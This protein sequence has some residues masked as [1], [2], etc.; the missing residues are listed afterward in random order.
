[1]TDILHDTYSRF[2]R[3]RLRQLSAAAIK[4]MQELE[5]GGLF[6]NVLGIDNLWDEACWAILDGFDD[7]AFEAA[8]LTLHQFASAEIQ[9]LLPEELSLHCYILSSETDEDNC[10]PPDK[11][12]MI[13]AVADKMHESANA[14]YFDDFEEIFPEEETDVDGAWALRFADRECL[15]TIKETVGAWRTRARSGHD[16]LALG[17]ILTGLESILDGNDPGMVV[18]VGLTNA[19]GVSD[20]ELEIDGQCLEIAL[21]DEGIELCRTLYFP[22]GQGRSRDH[23]TDVFAVL[24]PSGDF[25]RN[26]VDSWSSNC[27]D[28]M[29]HGA[30]IEASIDALPSYS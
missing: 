19:T 26:S 6:P 3:A 25:C 5:P 24:S 27:K 18:R 1:M 14:R 4:A 2:H 20:D 11:T 30:I 15:E 7:D 28:L 10:P 29:G 16:L 12:A 23:Q 17:A 8:V 22:T 13:N 9:D 21:S